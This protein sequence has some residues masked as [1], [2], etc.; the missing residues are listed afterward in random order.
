MKHLLSFVFL[1][2]AGVSA[3]AA[4]DD[5]AA[6]S[7]DLRHRI[8]LLG[9]ADFTLAVRTVG[10]HPGEVRVVGYCADRTRKIVFYCNSCA[11]APSPDACLD[12]AGSRVAGAEDG[13]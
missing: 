9:L 2:L 10:E 4:G 3:F 5:C 7:A 12:S 6:T 11:A 8:S 13:Y 1:A